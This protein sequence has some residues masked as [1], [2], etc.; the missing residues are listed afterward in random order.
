MKVLYRGTNR[1][2]LS[3][4]RCCSSGSEGYMENR[5]QTEWNSYF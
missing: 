1:Y 5:I 4:E 2:N 3:G